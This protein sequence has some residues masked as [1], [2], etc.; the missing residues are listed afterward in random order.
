[1]PLRKWQE[2]QALLWRVILGGKAMLTM[3]LGD[4]KSQ[5]ADVKRRLL[6][7]REYL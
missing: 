5:C 4:I 1:M 6:D 2:I 7:M 3:E